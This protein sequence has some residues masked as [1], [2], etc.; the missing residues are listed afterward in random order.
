MAHGEIDRWLYLLML[1]DGHWAK[2]C[3]AMQLPYGSDPQYAKLKMRKKAREQ[4]EDIM[5]GREPQPPSDWTPQL[6]PRGRD[7]KY[8]NPV[9]VG[10]I[11]GLESD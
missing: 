5:A 9:T 11:R 1:T 7:N 3:E 6:P 10:K 4:V 2:F 8:L